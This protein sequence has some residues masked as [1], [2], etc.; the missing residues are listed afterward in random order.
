MADYGSRFAPIGAALANMATRPNMHR[1]GEEAKFDVSKW[2]F[3]A[4][5]FQTASSWAPSSRWVA[6]AASPSSPTGRPLSEAQRSRDFL[7][8]FPGHQNTPQQ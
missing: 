1:D 3:G 6:E 5:G 4:I 7:R 8:A 2:L